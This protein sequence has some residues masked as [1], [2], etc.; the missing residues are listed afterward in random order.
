[1]DQKK[2]AQ[3][4]IELP[5]W[6]G[7]SVMASAAIENIVDYYGAIEI[8]IIGSLSSVET[9]KHHPKIVKSIIFESKYIS[10]YKNYNQLGGFD[11]YFTFRNSFRA[12]LL[13]LLVRSKNKYQ[14]KKKK[15]TKN[16]HQVKQYVQFVNESLNIDFPAGNLVVNNAQCRTLNSTKIIGINP[17][18]TYGSAKRWYPDEFAKIAIEL[19]DRFDIVIF[20]GDNERIFAE[21]IEKKLIQKKITNY[22]NLAGKTS[23]SEL[24]NEI[25]NLDLFITGDS[26]PMHIAASFKIPTISIFGPTNDHETSQWNNSNS[27]VIKKH[28]DC[29]PCMKKICPLNHHNCMKL[30]KAEDVISAISSIY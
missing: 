1:M 25:G 28:L 16:T 3:I 23:I 11:D 17:G 18:G 19:S 6:L 22:R 20:G 4:L 21:E 12:T 29:Q 26:G 30:I 10:L 27:L 9:L 24:I 7:D 13:K 15:S 5:T 2:T 14:F 8:T